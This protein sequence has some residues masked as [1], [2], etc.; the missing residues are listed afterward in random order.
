MCEEMVRDAEGLEGQGDRDAARGFA[1][2][3]LGFERRHRV[4]I[5]RFGRYPHRNGV[6]GRVSTG[7]EVEYLAGGGETFGG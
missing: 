5:E 4:I 7:E 1:E 3:L 6:L 2:T